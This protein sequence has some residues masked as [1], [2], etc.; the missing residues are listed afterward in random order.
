MYTYM[1]N[2]MYYVLY[3]IVAHA[4][5]R[6]RTHSRTRAGLARKERQHVK[7]TQNFIANGHKNITI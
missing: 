4:G 6:P 2:Y 5:R 3:Y 7:E 1:F